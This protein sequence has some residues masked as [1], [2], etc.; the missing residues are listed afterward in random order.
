MHRLSVR[1]SW[2]SFLSIKPSH[3]TC[4][5]KKAFRFKYYTE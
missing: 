5:I 4:E 3:F 1:V 2:I